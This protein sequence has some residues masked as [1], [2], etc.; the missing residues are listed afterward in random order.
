MGCKFIATNEG[1]THLLLPAEEHRNSLVSSRQ[2]I[3][4]MEAMSRSFSDNL[5]SNANAEFV[6]KYHNVDRFSDYFVEFLDA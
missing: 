5:A 1:D 2:A 6:E 4:F 3:D